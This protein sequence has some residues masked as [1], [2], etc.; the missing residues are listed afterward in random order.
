MVDEVCMTTFLMY[1]AHTIPPPLS[2]ILDLPQASLIQKHASIVGIATE[3][4]YGGGAW[5]REVRLTLYK[6]KSNLFPCFIMGDSL[7]TYL[8]KFDGFKLSYCCYNSNKH[9]FDEGVGCHGKYVLGT[10][11]LQ[12]LILH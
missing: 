3:D 9:S 12:K 1:S 2:K 7:P 4:N 6:G 8:D 10:V 5:Y 11:H